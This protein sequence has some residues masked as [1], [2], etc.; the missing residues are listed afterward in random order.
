MENSFQQAA[1]LQQG[2]NIHPH[3]QKGRIPVDPQDN[4]SDLV[5]RLTPPSQ[6]ISYLKSEKTTPR[7]PNTALD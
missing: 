3:G 5:R 1:S 6:Q 7:L 4:T 2:R